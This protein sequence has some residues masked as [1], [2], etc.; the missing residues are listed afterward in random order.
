MNEEFKQPEPGTLDLA[1]AAERCKCG[2]QRLRT[3]AT[4][5]VVPA[6][7]VG[8]R[9]VFSTRLLQEWIDTRALANLRAR[10]YSP[11]PSGVTVTRAL[12]AGNPVHSVAERKPQA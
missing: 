5:G 3:L 6:T 12:L 7:K 11:P 4:Q 2:I 9:W 8:R 1:Q 10:H